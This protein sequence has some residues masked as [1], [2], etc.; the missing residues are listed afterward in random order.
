MED[1]TKSVYAEWLEEFIQHIMELKPEKIGVCALLP[2][3]STLTHYFGG[4][5]HTDK[6]VM[7]YTMTQDAFMDVMYANAKEILEAA[8]EQDGDDS[9]KMRNSSSGL[10][11]EI[12]QSQPEAQDIHAHTVERVEGFAFHLTI[13]QK[14]S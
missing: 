13:Y 8:E 9:G 11:Q 14:R 7:G 5:Y 10:I 12:K 6:A 2:D 4:C 3:G 1:V